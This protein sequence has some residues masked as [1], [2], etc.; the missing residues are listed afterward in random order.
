M[1]RAAHPIASDGHHEVAPNAAAGLPIPEPVLSQSNP[2]APSAVNELSTLEAE[3]LGE[4]ARMSDNL[5]RVSL[6]RRAPCCWRWACG[7][8]LNPRPPL[9]PALRLLQLTSITNKLAS[10][11]PEIMHAIVPLEKKLGMVLTLFKVRRGMCLYKAMSNMRC[12]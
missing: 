9:A 4:Y 3:V 1:D 2:Y 8:C 12:R 10:S 11:Q 5:E 6:S 7:S